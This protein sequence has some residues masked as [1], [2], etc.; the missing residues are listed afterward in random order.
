MATTAQTEANRL[1]AQKSTGPRSEEGKA[2]SRFNAFKHGAYAR[3]RIIPGED[4]AD[5]TRLGERYFIE[6]RPDGVVE[7]RLVYTLIRCDWEMCRVPRLEAAAIQA[8]VAEQENEDPQLALGAA[9]VKDASGPNVSS[10]AATRPRIAIGSAP[11]A[12]SASARPSAS[13]APQIPTRRPNPLPSPSPTPLRRPRNL[14]R[15]RPPPSR[16]LQSP[17]GTN[18]IR[19]PPSRSPRPPSPHRTRS[20]THHR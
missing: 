7:V 4:E 9:L 20:P 17:S 8:F 19:S 5:L 1:N 18:P 10:S 6:L 3:E 14:S 12:T 2:S 16:S 11:K 15:P 13:H